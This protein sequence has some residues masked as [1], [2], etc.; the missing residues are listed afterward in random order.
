[1]T[2]DHGTLEYWQQVTKA[3][4][5]NAKPRNSLAVAEKMTASGADSVPNVLREVV[6]QA[7]SLARRAG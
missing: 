4:K 3:Q 2:A 6:E 1:M 5:K 7:R